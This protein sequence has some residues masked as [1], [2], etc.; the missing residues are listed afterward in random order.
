MIK[1]SG[2]VGLKT[3]KRVHPAQLDGVDGTEMEFS[4]CQPRLGGAAPTQVDHLLGHV[5]PSTALPVGATLRATRRTASPLPL[6]K[7]TTTSLFRSASAVPELPVSF[8]P[9][10]SW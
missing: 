5:D 1:N 7:S 9:C 3:P 8:L 6:P 4:V 10:V 2:N